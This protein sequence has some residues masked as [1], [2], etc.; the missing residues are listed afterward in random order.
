MF[1]VV[2]IAVLL[3]VLLS[4]SWIVLFAFNRMSFSQAVQT[5][6]PIWSAQI[7]ACVALIFLADK[8]GLLNPAGYSIGICV[9][10]GCAGAVFLRKSN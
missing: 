4:P 2:L 3:I 10:V 5:A 8:A 1:A 9:L 7:V 6:W